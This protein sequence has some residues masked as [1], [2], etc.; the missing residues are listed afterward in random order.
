MP[1]KRYGRRRPRRP[2]AILAERLAVLLE[3]LHFSPPS[4]GITRIQDG[5]RDTGRTA[6]RREEPPALPL[7]RRTHSLPVHP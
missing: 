4:E 2:K 6:R 7:D 3:Q 1:K 5:R